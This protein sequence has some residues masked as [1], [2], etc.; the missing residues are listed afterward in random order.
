MNPYG[1]VVGAVLGWI[2][3]GGQADLTAFQNEAAKKIAGYKNFATQAENK[4][5]AAQ[6]N[7]ARWSQSLSNK[8]HLENAGKAL[9]ASQI[10][11]RRATDAQARSGFSRLLK[12]DEQMGMMAAHAG[13]SGT[14]GSV[15]DSITQATLLRNSMA[16][17]Q[18]KQ[19]KSQQSFDQ[20]VAM[21]NIASQM[22][23]GINSSVILDNLNYG[24]ATYERRADA[25][26][27]HQAVMG[28][29]KGASMDFSSNT[30]AS[31]E[32]AK[33]DTSGISDYAKSQQ[34]LAAIG[35]NAQQ[36]N[37][38]FNFNYL[39]DKQD[40]YRNEGRNYAEVYSSDNASS[41]TA[42]NLWGY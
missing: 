17:E 2:E 35:R 7:L 18:S 41:D 33:V 5:A 12:Q 15:V 32:E 1:A 19:A 11:Y 14:R 23:G 42:M 38:K 30:D 31:K 37:Q 4:A 22:I 28:A 25:S 29:M 20:R 36:E 3:A 16:E 24:M 21:K 13:A 34:E 40:E 27:L 6:G 8:R 9:E 26:R 39:E 10:N